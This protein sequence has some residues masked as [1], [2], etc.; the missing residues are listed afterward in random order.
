MAYLLNNTNDQSPQ[1]MGR[2]KV[3]QALLQTGQQPVQSAGEGMAN[4]GS[5][6]IGAMMMRKANEPQNWMS[7]TG[8]KPMDIR[9]GGSGG[10]FG[11]FG[12]LAGMFGK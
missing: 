7:Q 5:S 10:G 2:Q 9:N 4:L 3:A 1:M 8:Q 11:G 12:R 6:A